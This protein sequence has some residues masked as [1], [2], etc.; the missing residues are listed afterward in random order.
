[1]VDFADPLELLQTALQ[2]FESENF[3]KVILILEN[4]VGFADETP[5]YYILL[6]KAYLKVGDFFKSA[7]VIQSGLDKFPFNKSLLLLEKDLKSITP[8][9]SVA[10]RSSQPEDLNNQN[11]IFSRLDF[12]ILK[13]LKFRKILW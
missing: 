2:E 7:N 5:L 8:R 3:N 11:D 9:S 6:S 13:V 12:D 1:M 4:G 10:G